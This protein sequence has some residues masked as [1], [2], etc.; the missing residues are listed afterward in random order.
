VGKGK[1]P[2]GRHD[3]DTGQEKESGC[4][5]RGVVSSRSAATIKYQGRT[6]M[7]V[8]ILAFGVLIAVWVAVILGSSYF[9]RNIK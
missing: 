3:C 7:E 8:V 4:E 1:S 2:T 6:D 9:N 5:G